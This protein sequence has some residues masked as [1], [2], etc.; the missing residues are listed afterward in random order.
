MFAVQMRWSY[1]LSVPFALVATVGVVAI[2]STMKRQV[3]AGVAIALV[4]FIL[5]P[6][7]ASTRKI[8]SME[9]LY[10]PELKAAMVWLKENT[11]EYYLATGLFK[12]IETKDYYYDLGSFDPPYKIMSWWPYGFYIIQGA[13][14][15]PVTDPTQRDA[16]IAVRFF[17]YGEGEPEY[18]LVVETMNETYPGMVQTLG[19]TWAEGVASYNASFLKQLIDNS[20]NRYTEVYNNEEVRIW[21]R[22]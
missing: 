3:K 11:P 10:T 4:F 12:G 6:G 13:H 9:P 8:V 19:G 18:V 21:Q 15:V 22:D 14:R 1:N 7:I 16:D 17:V 2:V 20:T 5:M